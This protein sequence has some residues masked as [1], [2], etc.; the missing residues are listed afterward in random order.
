[1]ADRVR[2]RFAPS[3]TGEPHI[4]NIRT[5][6]FDWLFARHLGGE[7]IIRVEDTDQSRK[8]E[9]SVEL[10]LKS[11]KWLG[12]DWDEGPDIGGEYGPYYQSERLERYQ[13]AA[14][15]LLAS[16]DAYRCFCSSERLSELRKQQQ[17]DRAVVTGY[18]GKCSDVSN[19][20][21]L[22]RV[23]AGE[24]AVIRFRMPDDG[25]TEGNDEIHGKVSFENNLLD[26]FVIIKS[27]GFPTY[28]LASIVDD[29]LM[30]IS[31]VT[32]TIEW[33]PSYPRHLQ[34]YRAMGWEPPTFV[35]LPL[36]LATDRTKLA[37]RHGATSVLEFQEMGM[38]PS[39][40]MNYLTLLGWSLDDKTEIFSSD[41][42]IK[43]FT[44][45]RVSKS[46]AVFDIEKLNWMNGVHIRDSSPEELADALS[47]YWSEYP[48]SEFPSPPDRDFALKVI[49]LVHARMKTLTDAA[50]LLPFFF[51]DRIGYEPEE[52]VQ[53]GMDSERTRIVLNA[54]SEKLSTLDPFDTESIENLLRPLSKELDVKVGQLLGSLRV[55][56]TG[57][58]VSPPI[59]ETIEALGRD[60][61]V[62]SIQD[63]IERL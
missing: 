16:G 26:D 31:H 42:L 36:V 24:S 61:T 32:R 62:K 47:G 9:G 7:F 49:P 48:T 46:D 52:L 35:H 40:M 54:A 45:E 53:K 11:L 41:E 1:M 59:F 3:P 20:D 28:H 18:D 33:L 50:P 57:L 37:K 25:V 21:A 4:G 10:M 8:V 34:V 15:A 22:D 12:I 58:K 2:V 17:V 6:I 44:L 38:L 55:A 43:H 60:Q 56:T 13:E 27:D 23:N 19:S 14:D 5:A 51:Q 30:E 39:A 63:A 29:H